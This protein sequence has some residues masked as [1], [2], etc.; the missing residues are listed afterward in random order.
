MTAL[1]TNIA[2]AISASH[3]QVQ[4]IAITSTAITRTD[5]ITSVTIADSIIAKIY[6]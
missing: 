5:T 1:T 4:G 6:C 3:N 2:A